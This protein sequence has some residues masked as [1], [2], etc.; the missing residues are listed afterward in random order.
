[1]RNRAQLTR[2]K[3][4]QTRTVRALSTGELPRQVRKDGVHNSSFKKMIP[5]GS[6]RGDH[7]RSARGHTET[8][9][10]PPNI[11]LKVTSR[12]PK[13]GPDSPPPVWPGFAQTLGGGGQF[14]P[15]RRFKIRNVLFLPIFLDFSPQGP[16]PSVY[17]SRR[18]RTGGLFDR[19]KQS[20]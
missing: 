19:E 4:I 14:G 3:C 18:R 20:K 16:P 13:F 6:R 5:H 1:M 12:A 11:P 17:V 10:G 7:R 15:D 2:S 9:L 8:C